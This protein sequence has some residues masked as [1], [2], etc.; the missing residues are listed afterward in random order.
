MCLGKHGEVLIILYTNQK[1][2]W[3]LQYNSLQNI[4]IAIFMSGSLS[5]L[6]DNLKEWLHK[7]KY[8]NYKSDHNT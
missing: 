3:K 8:K 2:N 6:A 7:G 5:G 1:R 4:D